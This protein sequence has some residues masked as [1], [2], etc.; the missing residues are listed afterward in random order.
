MTRYVVW[1]VLLIAP[2]LWAVGTA[3]F[4]LLQVTPGGPIVALTGEFAGP[5]TVAAIEARLGLDRPVHEQYLRFLGLLAQGDLGQSYFYKKPVLDVVAT[6]LASTLVLVVPSLV[7]AA[8]IGVPVGIHAARG[9]GVGAGLLGLSLLAFAVPVFW[10][11]HLLRLPFAV[12]LGWFPIH[13]M[14]DARA[15][16]AGLAH[17]LDV[18][19][20]AALPVLTLTLH[21]L[22]FTV[23][24]TRS[25]MLHER[26]RPY[27]V[28]ALMKGN[29]VWRAES[30]H[31]LPNGSLAIVTL[32]ANRIGWF[33]AGAVLVEV[34][35]AWPGLGQ[36]ANGAMQNRD[37]PLVIGL[38]LA[39]TVI[40]LLANLAADLI[41]MW[42][43]PRVR[44]AERR[45]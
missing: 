27:Y 19:H 41:Y 26:R 33:M 29:S 7:F 45:T 35:Y 20:H 8:L 4:V 12:E 3:L 36:L 34:V 10:L 42:I 6:H 21:Q 32:F 1:R 38:V 23:L 16:H 13:G 44:P 22:A 17:W 39:V 31:A 9:L 30:R 15:D 24:L 2:M 25:A 11:G 18:A 40:T 5:E 28:T 43:D 37:Y 14:V